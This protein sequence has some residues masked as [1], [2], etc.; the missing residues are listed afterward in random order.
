[1]DSSDS[2][3]QNTKA[4][5]AQNDLSSE[6]AHV[7]EEMY[8]K[9]LELAE[10]NKTLALLRKIDEIVLSEVTDPKEIAQQV[11]NLVV[12]EEAFRMFDIFL[13]DKDGKKL[14]RLAI[15]RTEAL[16]RAEKELNIAI[17]GLSVSLDNENNALA[18]SVNQKKMQVSHNLHDVFDSSFSD[19]QTQKI[20]TI[21]GAK[22]LLIFPLIVRLEVLGVIVIG[23]GE[24]EK[25]L[26]VYKNDLIDRLSGVV[27]IA[28]DNAL[29][30][31][32]IQEANEQ[33]KMLDKLKDEF[34]SL[35]S[36]ELRTPM[37]AIKYYLWFLL[38]DKDKLPFS[39][40]QKEHLERAYSST[41]RLIN[42]VNDMLNVSRI[43]GGRIELNKKVFQIKQLSQDVAAEVLPTAQKQGVQVIVTAA[44]NLPQVFAD[45]D[46]IKE[47]VINLVGN[48]IKFTPSGGT[49][50]IV[51][52]VLDGMMETSITDP[53][54]GIKAEDMPKL[55]K[56]FGMIGG[57]Y[58]TRSASQGTGLGLYISKSLVELH[59]GKIWVK[60]DGENKGTTFSFTLPLAT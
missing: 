56:K 45:S 52:Q 29:L 57:Q 4:P 39:D 13:L 43:E 53:G 11:A 40:K 14:T 55:F 44:D 12:S 47:V 23:I 16:A 31:K 8:K 34:V 1:M 27:G 21:I 18:R 49:I 38:Q 6:L 5:A 36:H 15:S 9:N 41:E 30:Y 22:S 51:S 54:I 42:L 35:A 2:T 7:T 33:L 32:K 28:I 3:T 17:D 46:K 50:T 59:G 60:S 58:L 37:T 25:P 24:D 26:S 19:D 10:T 20:Q 48:S